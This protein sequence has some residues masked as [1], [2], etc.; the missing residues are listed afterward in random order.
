MGDHGPGALLHRHRHGDPGSLLGDQTVLGR[1]RLVTT[2]LAPLLPRAKSGVSGWMRHV[3]DGDPRALEAAKGLA[4]TP[5]A[6]ASGLVRPNPTCQ[7][8]LLTCLPGPS[9]FMASWGA[10]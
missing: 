3:Q 6:F 10:S 8:R 5:V 7:R 9:T 4:S 2:S 1:Q